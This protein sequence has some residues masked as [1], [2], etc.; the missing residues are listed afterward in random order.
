MTLPTTGFG[1]QA[2]VAETPTTVSLIHW[3]R[4]QQFNPDDVHDTEYW[5]CGTGD[6]C[7]MNEDTKMPGTRRV[8]GILGTKLLARVLKHSFL[9][10]CLN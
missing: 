7:C 2:A 4:I 8:G 1:P 10:K 6:A 9:S 5:K 3:L